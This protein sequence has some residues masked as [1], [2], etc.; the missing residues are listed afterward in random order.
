MNTNFIDMTDRRFGRWTVV[1]PGERDRSGVRRWVCRCDCGTVKEVY[2][3]HLRKRLST[4]CGCAR[5]EQTA[6]RLTKHGLKDSREYSIWCNMLSRCHN[7]RA[8]EFPRYGARGICVCDRWRESFAAFY[9]DMGPCPSPDHSIDRKENSGHYEPGNCQWATRKEQ[10]RNTRK[11]RFIEFNGERLTVSEWA[12]RT[13]ISEATIRHR[14]DDAGW[15]AEKALTAPLRESP[16]YTYQGKSLTL[17]EWSEVTGISYH[18]IRARIRLGWTIE[19][20]L[21]HDVR[22]RCRPQLKS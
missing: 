21:T 5:D 1:R 6:I 17:R 12:E 18:N 16:R 10:A 20:A 2:G 19:D 4:S 15:P 11:N 13:G 14:L 22:P 8:T 3:K 9:E 7:P